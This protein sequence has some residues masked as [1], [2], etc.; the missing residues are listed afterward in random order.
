MGCCGAK[1]QGKAAASPGV[2]AAAEGEDS[3]S[4]CGWYTPYSSDDDKISPSAVELRKIW[5][6]LQAEQHGAAEWPEFSDLWD[7]MKQADYS[8]L[9]GSPAD[10]DTATCPLKWFCPN[11]AAALVRLDRLEGHP[12]TGLFQGAEHALIRLSSGLKPAAEI[13]APARW[14]LFGKL[15]KA[16]LF[17]MVALKGLRDHAH[18]GNLLLGGSKTGQAETDFFAHSVCTNMTERLP[19]P[20]RPALGPLRKESKFPL[21]LGVS[22]FAAICQDGTHE[23][24]AR[25]PWCVLFR[26]C[27]GVERPPARRDFVEQLVEIPAGT[28]L[29][30]GHASCCWTKE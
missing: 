28:P 4:D 15:K 30:E 18:S 1:D 12:Y 7:H 5:S 13:P 2:G 24:R 23:P 26:P 21:S 20:L 14:A 29:Y 11:G 25:F 17:P 6:I 22:H 8:E 9:L 3:D 19:L 16:H 27:P 10:M